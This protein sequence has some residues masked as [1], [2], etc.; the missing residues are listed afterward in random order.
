MSVAVAGVDGSGPS[1]GVDGVVDRF[2]QI[3]PVALF[4]AR[5]YRYGGKYH[6][7]EARLAEITPR[8]PTLRARPGSR[9]GS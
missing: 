8:L 1:T 5:G 2:G 4:A 6:D 7:C 9:R 3:G